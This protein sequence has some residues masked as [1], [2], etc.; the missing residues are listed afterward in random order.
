MNAFRIQEE[1]ILPDYS[2][3]GESETAL[4]EGCSDKNRRVVDHHVRMQPRVRA[5]DDDSM[6]KAVVL[7]KVD[8]DVLGKLVDVETPR[9]KKHP[10]RSR[11]QQVGSV[12]FLLYVKAATKLLVEVLW[13]RLP[14]RNLQRRRRQP[15]GGCEVVSPVRL[16]GCV[17]FIAVPVND[18]TEL[19][20]R[21]RGVS[22]DATHLLHEGAFARQYAEERNGSE[23]RGVDAFRELELVHPV[24]FQTIVRVW[25]PLEAHDIVAWKLLMDPDDGLPSLLQR[26]DHLID[27]SS[28][29]TSNND[30]RVTAGTKITIN[31]FDQC[32]A[33]SRYEVE[34]DRL[35]MHMTEDA[36][37]CGHRV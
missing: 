6:V 33:E 20:R 19:T 23:R 31:D 14:V 30:F 28:R 22:Q 24:A 4:V 34:G 26:I 8:L 3:E 7:I 15:L 21:T 13:R 17:E 1:E 9:H 18:E 12:H 29:V 10:D 27:L 25:H 36:R 32:I 35:E 11:K 5:R 37:L 2:V 16:P